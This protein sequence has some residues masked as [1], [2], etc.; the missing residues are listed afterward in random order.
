[1]GLGVPIQ[2]IFLHL[3]NVLYDGMW[4]R[5]VERENF[6][7]SFTCLICYSRKCKFRLNAPAGGPRLVFLEKVNQ[8]SGLSHASHF[9]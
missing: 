8:I 4:R 6:E 9:V 1:M 5:E 3:L 2:E 7:G